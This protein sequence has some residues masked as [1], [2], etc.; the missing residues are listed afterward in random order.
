MP[1]AVGL[2]AAIGFYHQPRSAAPPL[3]LD[4][5]ELF[6]TTL[7]EMPLIGSLNRGQWDADDDFEI[8]GNQVWLTS[9]CVP[10]QVGQ[11]R[12]GKAALGIESD[13]G[14]RR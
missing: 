14:R 8:R 10:L 6:R 5:M 11:H 13:S 12:I 7:W 4:V 2:E 3:V 9:Q 1:V